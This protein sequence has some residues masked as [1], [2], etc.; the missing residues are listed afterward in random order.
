[1][2]GIFQAIRDNFYNMS[3]ADFALTRKLQQEPSSSTQSLKAN[4]R[5]IC[6]AELTSF[7]G[8]VWVNAFLDL[9]YV[10]VIFKIDDILGKCSQQNDRKN[11][12]EA[13]ANVYIVAIAFFVLMFFTRYQM[14]FYASSFMQLSS[15]KTYPLLQADMFHR[16]MLVLYGLG[17]FIM[18]MNINLEEVHGNIDNSFLVGSCKFNPQYSLGF[19][20]GFLITRGL[21]CIMYLAVMF[22]AADPVLRQKY[23][24]TFLFK[25][26]RNIISMVLIAGL[27]S[28]IS[29]TESTNQLNISLLTLVAILEVSGEFL[30]TSTNQM[31]R[32]WFHVPETSSYFLEYIRFDVQP[33]KSR[34]AKKS[35]VVP[36][37]SYDGLSE[38]VELFC[39]ANVLQ[40]RLSLFFMLIL[41]ESFLGVLYLAYNPKSESAF[42]VQVLVYFLV[43]STGTLF[44]ETVDK[45]VET[46]KEEEDEE[47][48]EEERGSHIRSVSGSVDRQSVMM[49]RKRNK[50]EKVKRKSHQHGLLA[51]Y[52]Y[53]YLFVWMHVVV[54]FTLL[55]ATCGIVGLYSNSSLNLPE[56]RRPTHAKNSTMPSSM[57]TLMPSAFNSSGFTTNLTTM[58]QK[59]DAIISEE[60][61][62]ATTNLNYHYLPS[63]FFQTQARMEAEEETY[64]TAALNKDPSS[65]SHWWTRLSASLMA[66]VHPVVASF[67]PRPFQ[68][69]GLDDYLSN[70]TNSN[71]DDYY[72]LYF[73]DSPNLPE[74][75]SLT[76]SEWQMAIG[77]SLTALGCMFMRL[78][79]RTTLRT[80]T[81]SAASSIRS[82][83]ASLRDV[84]GGGGS[85]NG[86]STPAAAKQSFFQR[87]CHGWSVFYEFY[88]LELMTLVAAVGHIL[89]YVAFHNYNPASD[90]TF[91]L[92]AW[93]TIVNV[94]LSVVH[95]VQRV[96]VSEAHGPHHGSEEE[97]DSSVRSSDMVNNPLTQN[98]A[99]RPLSEVK[100][101]SS[102]AL[103]EK[104]ATSRQSGSRQSGAS[105]ARPRYISEQDVGAEMTSS[106]SP[107]EHE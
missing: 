34:D 67:K 94:A 2:P 39:D 58:L 3:R 12:F 43:V 29:S 77:L 87:L 82:V 28:N 20:S 68:Y 97:T 85:P 46:G 4:L 18:T 100:S 55:L 30:L 60:S 17:M 98:R 40:E 9:I 86:V 81:D 80:L 7:E 19:A 11:D 72:Y 49:L 50:E 22:V 84:E 35:D 8:I 38:S 6:Q 102:K 107:S 31:M 69:L 65:S 101:R 16:A 26:A 1:M 23:R 24:G 57:P 89:V 71:T 70:G 15:T 93:H 45:S 104:D 74:Y 66:F 27:F 95:L 59:S 25:I 53:S 10:M 36:Y 21:M 13:A 106:H 48:E 14:D 61:S 32:H 96:T 73:D 54:A 52:P 37:D 88:F 91:L 78:M 105:R 33:E 92:F 47:E 42:L 103:S 62:D 79:H 5:K 83:S 51:P 44:F 90:A 63:L 76:I 64:E 99:S 56:R 75:P 41:G